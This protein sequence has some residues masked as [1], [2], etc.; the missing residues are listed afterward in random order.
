MTNEILKMTYSTNEELWKL[1]HLLKFAGFQ[2]TEECYW[3]QIY[4]NNDKL[5]VLER[6]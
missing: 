6:N 2:K 5:V 1:E 3:V 4:R